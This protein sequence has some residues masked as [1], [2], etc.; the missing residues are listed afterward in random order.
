[1]DM[2]ER[3]RARVRPCVPSIYSNKLA[4][5]LCVLFFTTALEVKDFGDIVK[6]VVRMDGAIIA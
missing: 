3:E 4:P 5:Y 1:M 6:L 2:R